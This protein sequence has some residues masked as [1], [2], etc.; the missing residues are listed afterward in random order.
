MA[1]ISRDGAAL[2][3]SG[4]VLV[5]SQKKAILVRM[6]PELLEELRAWAKSELRS[7]NAQIELLLRQALHERSEQLKRNESNGLPQTLTQRD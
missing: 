7:L 4:D 5:V 6:S 1:L 3:D 2:L